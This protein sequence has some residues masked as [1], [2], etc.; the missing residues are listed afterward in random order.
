M[1]SPA[2]RRLRVLLSEGGSTSARQAITMLGL[3]GHHVEICDPSPLCLGR[4]SRFVRAVHRC[5][6]LRRDP[7]GYLGFVTELLGRRGFDVLL[8]IHEQGLVF[9]RAPDRI[10]ALAGVALPSY[11]SYR[12]AVTKAGFSRLLEKLGLPQ[13]PTRIVTSEH[14]FREAA[15]GRCVIKTSVGTASR[16]VWRVTDQ[17]ALDQAVYEL[18]AAEGFAGELLVQDFIAGPIEH[19]QAVFDRGDLLAL[20]AYRQIETGA[21]GG[22]SRK[23]S[24]R[25]DA[26]RA[27]VAAIGAALGWHGALSFDVIRPAN[28]ARPLYIDCNPRLVEPMSAQLAGLDL[29]DLLLRLSLGEHPA[30]PKP[31]RDG[32]CS[33]LGMQALLGCALRSGSRRDVV[34]E[35]VRL[36]LRQ[37]PYAGSAEELTPVGHDGFSAVPLVATAVILLAA[38]RRATTLAAKGWGD[39]LLDAAALARI[40]RGCDQPA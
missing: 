36:M 13:P 28:D 21:G 19:A 9:A 2:G 40:D 1:T 12:T 15:R 16:G 10:A 33:H 24:I 23:L 11:G 25:G 39:H 31:S 34:R 6:P 4:F 20:H 37:P 14:E 7:A 5:P 32:V 26:V 38:P 29:V 18:R 27:D 17:A 3:A 8:P 22:P 30:A 35:C